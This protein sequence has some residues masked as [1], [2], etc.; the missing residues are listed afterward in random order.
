MSDLFNALSPAH[1]VPAGHYGVQ[2]VTGVN[3]QVVANL[4]AATL[5]ARK[6]KTAELIAAATAAGLPLVDAPKASSGAGLEAIGTGPGKWF[7]FSEGSDGA[8]LRRRL[9]A[10]ATGLGAV[11]DQSDANLVLDI[12]GPK[13]R[14]ALV[15]GVAVDIDPRAFQ[16]GDA[17][18]TPVSHVGV[19]FWQRSDAPSYRFAV[20]N[21]FAPAFLRWLATSAAEY[22]F[23]LS[24]TDR[25]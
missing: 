10:L 20:G 16:P 7:V 15:K 24:G 14:E 9:E 1:L 22:G 8:T 2:G 6:G 21:T 13:V 25:G 18:T 5:M 23:A 11:T 17:A 12:S 19:T 4:A 3:A